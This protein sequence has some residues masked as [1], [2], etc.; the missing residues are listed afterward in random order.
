VAGAAAW[1]MAKTPK[2]DLVLGTF[3]FSTDFGIFWAKKG[4][5]LILAMRTQQITRLGD[6][7]H[8]KSCVIKSCCHIG[9]GDFF[10]FQLLL[11]FSELK[12]AIN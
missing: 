6:F 8:Y 5:K 9:F 1:K 4:H 7:S 3:S 10:L 11:A 2:P 12:K